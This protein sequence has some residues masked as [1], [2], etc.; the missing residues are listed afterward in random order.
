LIAWF[1]A[2]HILTIVA[3]PFASLQNLAVA[4]VL[5]VVTGCL[6]ITMGFH[7]LLSH[8]SFK[9][10]RPFAWFLALCGSLAFQGGVLEWVA[11]HRMHHAFTDSDDDPHNARR[12]FW[13]SHI[14]WLFAGVEKFDSPD[15]HRVF[16]RDIYRDPVM[17]FLSNTWTLAALQAILLLGLTVTLGWDAALWGVFVRICAGYHC[18]WLVNSATHKWGYRSY[19]TK[20]DSRNCWWVAILT[21]GEGWHNNHHADDRACSAGRRFWEID[22]TYLAIRAL[23]VVGLVWDIVPPKSQTVQSLQTKE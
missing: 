5:W 9:T 22:P 4:G 12:G 18:T 7:R 13:H 1:A 3:L 23:A 16:A 20:E 15:R 14:T 21:F 10:S 6:G 19:E 11:R 2:V 17:R 8:R